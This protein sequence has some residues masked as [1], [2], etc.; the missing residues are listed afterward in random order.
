MIGD[1]IPLWGGFRNT[2]AFAPAEKGFLTIAATATRTIRCRRKGFL[3][4]SVFQLDQFKEA[5]LTCDLCQL[6]NLPPFK[7]TLE[8]DGR[9]FTAR[10]F[11]L[12]GS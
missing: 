2:L 8:R 4:T 10:S 6:S 7:V 5:R 9:N 1:V 11:G 3:K 12:H